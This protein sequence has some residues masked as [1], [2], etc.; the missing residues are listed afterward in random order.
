MVSN[1]GDEFGEHDG[2]AAGRQL[3]LHHRPLARQLPAQSVRC[4]ARHGK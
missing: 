3:P 4:E 2:Q 1:H